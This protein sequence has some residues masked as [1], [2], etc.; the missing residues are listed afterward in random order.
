MSLVE[1]GW[2]DFF[3]AQL[4]LQQRSSGHYGRVCTVHRGGLEL[5]TQGGVVNAVP[6][7]RRQPVVGDWVTFAESPGLVAV[8]GVLN[9]LTKL[10]RKTAGREASE[11]I[12]AAN[13]D[14]VLIVMG[15]DNNYNLRRLE[16]FLVMAWESG[17][18]PLVVLTKADLQDQP[19]A[20]LHDAETVSSGVPV[21]L[22]DS[23]SGAGLGHLRAE[24]KFGETAVMV[25]SSGAGKST[26]LN[27][28]YGSEIVT[29]GAVREVDSKGRHTTTHRELVV[30]PGGGVIIDNPGVREIQ[31]WEGGSGLDAT[32][33][34]V[35]E[36]AQGCRFRDC[37]HGA[38]PGCA[39]QEGIAKRRLDPDRLA[40]Y[41]ALQSEAAGLELRQNEAKRRASERQ[42]GRLYKATQAHKRKRRG[43]Q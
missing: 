7:G 29:T 12:V 18:R 8:S 16:R 6:T 24:L 36:L 15:L 35:L 33:S 40:N 42:F 13:I 11:Q 41:L 22:C 19:K 3:S 39:V 9:R 28:L 17:A 1:Y 4:T 34:D 38:E 20:Y 43:K 5:I 26:L 30:L 10:S 2:R 27:G 32:F 37:T 25:G 23:L 21:L 14:T 31:P